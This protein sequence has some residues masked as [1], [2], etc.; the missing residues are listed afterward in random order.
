M[1]KCTNMSKTWGG[2]N[3]TQPYETCTLELDKN[4]IWEPSPT[5]W[6][7]A[8]NITLNSVSKNKKWVY[9]KVA[10]AGAPLVPTRFCTLKWA[11]SVPKVLPMIVKRIKNGSK[12]PHDCRAPKVKPIRRLAWRT[13]RSAYNTKMNLY[14]QRRPGQFFRYLWTR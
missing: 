6:N 13:A 5:N 10:P 11:P 9:L 2:E 3:I 4:E 14:S 12:K 1:D 7:N 8:Q